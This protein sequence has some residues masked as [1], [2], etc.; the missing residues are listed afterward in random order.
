M[1][2]LIQPNIP[3][4]YEVLWEKIFRWFERYGVPIWA[5]KW[6]Q[7]SRSVIDNKREIT[8]I[9]TA[10]QSWKTLDTATK[11]AWK[12]AAY[13]AYKFY[14]GYRLFVA[15]YIWRQKAEL[16]LPGTPANEHQLFGLKMANPGGGL[17][18]EMR[19]DDKDLVGKLKIKFSYKKDEITPSATDAFKVNCT[20]YYFTAGYYGTD[21]DSF[22]APAG[23]VGWNIIERTF[24]ST[25]RKY[26]HFKIVFTTKD[27]DAIIYLD[28]VVL[29]DNNGEFFREGWNTESYAAWIP[30][31]L[32]RKTDWQFKPVW[33]EPYFK[34][35]YLE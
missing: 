29:S 1:A 17:D 21:T 7:T 32:Y 34:H 30:R 18:V 4:E 28:N 33:A 2:K 14:R 31:A 19:R 22:S 15:D 25:N 8:K 35:E 16:S 6:F 9:P 11:G 27:Y 12:A 20:A 5:R 13:R 3:P 26:F 10:A 23:D 24:G